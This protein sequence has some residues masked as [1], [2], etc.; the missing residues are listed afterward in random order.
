MQIVERAEE[1]D[2]QGDLVITA[3]M[4]FAFHEVLA[5]A[6]GNPFIADMLIRVHRLGTRFGYAA[7][8]HEG[9]A[10]RSW[11]EHRAIVEAIEAGDEAL[12]RSRMEE[13]TRQSIDRII[14]ALRAG[15]KR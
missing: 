5:Q 15:N 6:T 11:A 7:W 13:H 14:S 10:S 12:A 1:A 2:R 4:D 8:K 3:D 9:R